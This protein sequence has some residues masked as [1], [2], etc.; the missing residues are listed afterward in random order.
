[1]A[2]DLTGMEPKPQPE[3]FKDRQEY[4]LAAIFWMMLY[5]GLKDKE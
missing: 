2:K 1:M 3:D 5:S 4:V